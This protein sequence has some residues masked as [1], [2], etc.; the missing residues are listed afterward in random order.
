MMGDG[1]ENVSSDQKVGSQAAGR[2]LRAERL[3]RS[4]HPE[5]SATTDAKLPNE[6]AETSAGKPRSATK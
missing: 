3:K 4:T 2:A 5:M 1:A 6:K